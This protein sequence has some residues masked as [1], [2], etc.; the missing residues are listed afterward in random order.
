M[1]RSEAE[2]LL[3]GYATGTLTEDERRRLFAA[4]LGDQSIFDA[5]VDE[6]TLRELLADPAMKAQLLAA[7]APVAAPKVVP[8]W[9]RTGVL[10]A[11]ASLLVAATAGLVYLRSPERVPLPLEQEREQPAKAAVPE[12]PAIPQA[13][14]L[15]ARK[16]TPASPV[17]AATPAPPPPGSVAALAPVPAQPMTAALAEG[18]PA[19]PVEDGSR[20]R[21]QDHYRRSEAQDKVAKKAETPRPSAAVVEVVAEAKDDRQ[22]RKEAARNVAAGASVAV[23]GGVVGGVVGGVMGG[24]VAKPS[25]AAPPNSDRRV[26][27]KA[28]AAEAPTWTLEP[29]PDGST[30]VL[31]KGPAGAQAVLLRRGAGGIRALALRVVQAGGD[32]THWRAEVRLAEGDVVDL[33]LLNTPAANP[34]LLPETGPVDGFRARVYPVARKVPER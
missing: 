5:L 10:G 9:R 26:V 24:A 29:Q 30:L 19:R 1:T 20:T 7:L 15:L 13:P 3:G 23:P 34:T 22:K 18:A 27:G 16:A 31:V 17:R 28:V 8:F 32:T 6:E 14:P 4:A 2:K 11:A 21:E 12:A 33:Y 25:A